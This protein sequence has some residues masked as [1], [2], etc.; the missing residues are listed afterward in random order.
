V[1][2]R[3]FAPAAQNRSDRWRRP[4]PLAAESRTDFNATQMADATSLD[5]VFLKPFGAATAAVPPEARS[6]A[7]ISV[8]PYPS[9]S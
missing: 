1:A 3:V 9:C 8:N 5:E 7:L 6:R 2:A 4:L